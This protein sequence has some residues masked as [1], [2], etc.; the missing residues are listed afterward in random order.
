MG[1][2]ISS[3]IKFFSFVFRSSLVPVISLGENELYQ[4]YNLISKSISCGFGHIPLRCP[5]IT[6]GKPIHINENLNATSKFL[7]LNSQ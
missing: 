4:Q 3:T 5:V 6:V 7:T 1:K 2:F